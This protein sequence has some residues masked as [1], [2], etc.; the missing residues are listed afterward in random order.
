VNIKKVDPRLRPTINKLNKMGYTTDYSCSGHK[1]AKGKV[2]EG[3]VSI[4]GRHN[5]DEVK[6]VASGLGLSGANVSIKRKAGKPTQ[7]TVVTFKG[8]GGYSAEGFDGRKS[9]SK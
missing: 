6:K 2:S 5:V 4:L 3:Y 8:L 7:R 1:N 9:R